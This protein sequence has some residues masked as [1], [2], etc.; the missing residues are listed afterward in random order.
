[1]R[2]KSSFV[3]GSSSTRMGKR[4]C[5]S[6]IRSDGLETWKAPAAMNRMWSVRTM[7]YLVVTVEPST[8]GRRSRCTPSRDTSG[9]WLRSRPAILS[10]SSRK[11]MPEFSNPA[12]GLAHRLVDVHELLGLLLDE[13]PPRLADL[14]P[15]LARPAP[16]HE[17][18]EHVL[19]VDPD[20]LHAL[21]GEHL[22]HGPRLRLHVHLDHP[23]VELARPELGRACR[24]S[25]PARRRGTPLRGCRS[26]RL[27]P[28]AAAARGRGA[29]PRP[30]LPPARAPPRPSPP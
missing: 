6:G 12:D 13:E 7:P 2:T 23:L 17:V 21:A 11:M 28:G 22:E 8:M 18:R 10:S 19:D 14:D 15:A 20:L 26:R 27:P 30:A 9:P 5:S 25:R 16:R 24:G 4:P 29:G 1:M 3:K